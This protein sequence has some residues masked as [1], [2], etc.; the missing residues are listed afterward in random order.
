[1]AK[2][3]DIR[4]CLITGGGVNANKQISVLR[5]N[6]EI[7]I[8]TPGRIVDHL[9]NTPNFGI[10]GV[11]IL[12]L[13]EADRLLEMGFMPQIESILEHVPKARQTMLFSAT[14]TDDVDKL[15]KL[16]L[17][18]PIRV[19]VDVRTNV[20][21][22]LT[23]EFIRIRDRNEDRE[24]ILLSLCTR[25]FTEK[26]IIFCNLKTT[27]RKLHM[28]FHIRGLKASELSGDLQQATVRFLF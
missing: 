8:A 20:A 5:Q 7:V 25:S 12:V 10:E 16:S 3:T 17:K 9:V 24:A 21:E 27:V 28:L 6:P 22:N 14:M 13:D 23:Q 19:A 18:N 4:C 15:I 2:H 11:E 26:T 1:L